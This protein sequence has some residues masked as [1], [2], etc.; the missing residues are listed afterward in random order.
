MNMIQPIGPRN[1]T[2][3]SQPMRGL[4][5]QR[6]PAGMRHGPADGLSATC[7]IGSRK[8]TIRIVHAAQTGN[9]SPPYTAKLRRIDYG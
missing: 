6:E 1:S 5:G 2:M 7:S 3:T 4:N 9:K 8:P